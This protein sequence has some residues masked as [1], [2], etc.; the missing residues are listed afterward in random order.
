MGFI[1]QNQQTKS[2][3]KNQLTKILGKKSLRA[4]FEPAIPKGPVV[5]FWKKAPKAGLLIFAFV[6]LVCFRKNSQNGFHPK[7]WRVSQQPLFGCTSLLKREFI[8]MCNVNF[9]FVLGNRCIQDR[10]TTRFRNI[11]NELVQGFMRPQRENR[12]FALAGV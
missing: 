8:S 2:L 10:R 3:N 4:G 5:F 9:T 7:P 1:N 12:S 11:L 6:S